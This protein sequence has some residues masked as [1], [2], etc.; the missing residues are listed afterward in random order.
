MIP[1]REL[2]KH[3]G[4]A[5]RRAGWQP[6]E[7]PLKFARGANLVFSACGLQTEVQDDLLHLYNFTARWTGK[8]VQ[9]WAGNKISPQVAQDHED[10]LC[11]TGMC[12]CCGRLCPTKSIALWGEGPRSRVG[13]CAT[14]E[15][16]QPGC[17]PGAI[18]LG[19]VHPT[20]RNGLAFTGAAGERVASLMGCDQK[21]LGSTTMRVNLTPDWECPRPT[22]VS[23]PMYARMHM[24]ELH[25]SLPLGV[26]IIAFGQMAFI[27]AA[28]GAER[29]ED[30][31]GI[32]TYCI[33]DHTVYRL[34][35]PSNRL[36]NAWA[37]DR[38]KERFQQ[39]VHNLGLT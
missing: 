29:L 28:W 34:P 38:L 16:S 7:S 18:L 31:H 24:W 23:R 6:G 2:E 4:E 12:A 22:E 8:T 36:D 3:V 37:R 5:A 14:C 19:E 11:D 13:L 26:P 25:P 27:G 15:T 35:H 32:E 33:P 39:L 10:W 17:M 30:T 20:I 21:T 9:A 1:F